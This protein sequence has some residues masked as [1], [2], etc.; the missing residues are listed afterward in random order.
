M[1]D[2]KKSLWLGAVL[3][4]CGAGLSG[5][6]GTSAQAEPAQSAADVEG[7]DSPASEEMG[8]G[9]CRATSFEFDEVKAAC[10]EGGVKQAQKLMKEYVKKAKAAGDKLKCS[11]CHVNTK[12]YELTDNAVEDL[13]AL[14][15]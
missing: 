12:T 7:G 10:D 6:G 9:S 14:L 8:A 5:C 1:N 4:G 3:A 13:R 11:S 2:W 15:Q